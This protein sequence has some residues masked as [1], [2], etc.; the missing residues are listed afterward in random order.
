M[1]I[2]RGRGESPTADREVTAALLDRAA[3]AGITTIRVWRP[4]RHLAFGRRDAAAAAYDHARRIARDHGYPPIERQV[5]GRAVAYTGSMLAFGVALPTENGR[6]GI[7]ERYTTATR[8]LRRALRETGACVEAGEPDASFC[9]GAH[10]LRVP[11]GGKV[12]GI[13]QRVRRDAVLVA[14]CV[15]VTEADAAA[16]GAVLDPV[17]RALDVAFDPDA[18]GSVEAAGGPVAIGPVAREIEDRFINSDW[19]NGTRR[20]RSVE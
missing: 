5:G 3:D 10:S 9:P 6:R 2:L 18:V 15:I 20:V 14:G 8:I 1:E 4:H 12:A 7:D 19:G 13:A 16:V 11:A 17:Y